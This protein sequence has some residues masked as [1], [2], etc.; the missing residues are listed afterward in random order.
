MSNLRRNMMAAGRRAAVD[1]KS[2][3]EG[4]CDQTI[5]EAVFPDGITSIRYGL[6][7]QC[8]NLT[9]V[10][11]PN[12]VT[13]I[14][15]FAFCYCSGLTGTLTIPSSVALIDS[16]AFNGCSR[17]TQ[18]V[19]DGN[20]LTTIQNSAFMNCGLTGDIV[21][22]DSLQIIGSSC[23]RSM[24]N[25]TSI[26]VG[27]G[28][29]KIDN[30]AFYQN[31]CLSHIIIR[32]TTPPTLGN[33]NA[34][35]STN[36]CPIYVPDE[37]VEAYKAAKNWSALADRIKPLSELGGGKRVVFNWLCGISAERSAA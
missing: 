26:T 12:S 16:N 27:T 15:G 11:I 35:N 28:I 29:T 30:F 34:F 37:S 10:T 19:I 13:S 5:A 21:L 9:S 25:V 24:A 3:Y 4:L 8:D 23:F 36:S 20:T 32:A 31:S 1:W 6:F 17:L 14:G 18:L 22:P 2:L 7:Y 33:V